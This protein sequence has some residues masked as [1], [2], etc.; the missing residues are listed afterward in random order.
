MKIVLT[1]DEVKAIVFQHC[2]KLTTADA[3]LLDWGTTRTKLP[4]LV[5]FVHKYEDGSGECQVNDFCPV[6]R[7]EVELS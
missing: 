5:R 3:P 4:Q 7:V 1:L 6:D 2:V